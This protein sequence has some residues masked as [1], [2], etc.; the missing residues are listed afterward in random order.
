VL[1]LEVQKGRMFLLSYRV[2]GFDVLVQVGI[3]ICAFYFGGELK[4]DLRHSV[5]RG[6]R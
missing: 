2:F 6:A 1:Q 4:G 3:P 5:S